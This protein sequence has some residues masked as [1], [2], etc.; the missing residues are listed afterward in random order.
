MQE[1]YYANFT[2][3]WVTLIC[4]WYRRRPVG[5][6]GVKVANIEMQETIRDVKMLLYARV[7]HV[8]TQ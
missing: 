1:T 4:P 5:R 7:E 8:I 6:L 2:N 3:G